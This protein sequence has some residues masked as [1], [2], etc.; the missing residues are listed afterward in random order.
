VN[1]WR[2][3]RVNYF[4]S[5]DFKEPQQEKGGWE[6]GSGWGRVIGTWRFFGKGVLILYS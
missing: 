1:C 2:S 6:G 4:Y 3:S 5:K